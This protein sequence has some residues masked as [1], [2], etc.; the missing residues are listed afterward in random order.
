M[1]TLSAVISSY[2]HLAIPGIA[3]IVA[4]QGNLPKI[5]ITTAQAEAEIYFHGAQVTSWHPAG[6]G[7]VIFLSEK[8]HWED[9]R[10][11]RGGVPICFPWFRA[12]ANDAKAPAH[13]FV[14]TKAWQLDSIEHNQGAVTVTLSTESNADTR[15]LWPHEF[16]LV[17][18]VTIGTQLKLELITIN[19]GKTGFHFEEA[20]HT[21]HRVS[22][23]RHV[24]V[25]GLDGV[26]FL[27]NTASNRES[28]QQGD[29]VFNRATDNAYLN[30]GH[31][32]ELID[33]QMGRRIRV[34]KENSFSTI[35]WNPWEAGAK[36]LADFGD[37]EW[38]QMVCA[39]AS[40]ILQF[41]VSLEAG[42]QHA[43]TATM[44]IL[45]SE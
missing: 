41:A 42:E 6:A 43:M 44:E 30:T 19:T 40:N 29:V 12:K 21:Y 18:R 38:Q 4:G 31:A 10:A 39:E 35:V 13:G 7:E 15:L 14:R 22:D 9:G 1:E 28:L 37:D 8:S 2:G 23:I 27:D 33:S 17:H 20:L 24:H 3:Q 45:P 5:H 36:A 26:T 25:A 16:R 32:L 34:K 11:I